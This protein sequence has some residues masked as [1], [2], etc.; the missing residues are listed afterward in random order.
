MLSTRSERVER[1]RVHRH[2]NHR[3]KRR[4][5]AKLTVGTP[6]VGELGAVQRARVISTRAYHGE[7]LCAGDGNWSLAGRLRCIAQRALR[8]NSPAKR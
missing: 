1:S 6:A 3:A 5:V 8:T 4:P 7:C 2:W